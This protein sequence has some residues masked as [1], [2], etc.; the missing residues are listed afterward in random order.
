MPFSLKNVGARYQILV[1]RMLKEKPGTPYRYTS[2][3][4]WSNPR[5]P[6][7]PCPTV[8]GNA[9][10]CDVGMLVLSPFTY[11]EQYKTEYVT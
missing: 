8:N 11:I 7:T 9:R 3:I 1:N 10:Q 5:E 2:M 6:I 4:C